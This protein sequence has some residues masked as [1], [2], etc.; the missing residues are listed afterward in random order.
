MKY[1]LDTNICIYHVNGKFQNSGILVTNN[2]GE[3]SRIDGLALED[4]AV[5]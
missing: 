3:F 5:T 4:W 1:F 2:I